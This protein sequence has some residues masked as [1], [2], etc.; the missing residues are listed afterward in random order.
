MT[1]S[2]SIKIIKYIYEQQMK[3]SIEEYG[4]L[5]NQRGRAIKQGEGM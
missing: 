5:K 1:K 4:V 2:W 3:Y